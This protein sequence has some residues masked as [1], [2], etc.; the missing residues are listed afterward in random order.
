[1][2]RDDEL[3]DRVRLLVGAEP[4][5]TEQRMFGGIA[6]LVGGNLAVS[7]SGQGGL[8]VRADRAAFDELVA[9][10]PAEPMEMRGRP[11]RGWLRVGGE[12]VRTDADLARWVGIGVGHARSLPA[13]P[14]P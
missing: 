4:G 14:G 7:A 1:M 3:A 13:K 6:F 8:L 9:T 10:T 5:V 12:H 11:M 2:P